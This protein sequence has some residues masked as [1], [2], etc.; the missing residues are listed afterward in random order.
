MI[1]REFIE[2]LGRSSVG[3]PLLESGFLTKVALASSAAGCVSKVESPSNQVYPSLP[4][5]VQDDIQ[6]V[7]GLESY[8]M[9]KEGDTINAMGERFGANNDFLAYIPFAKNN[10]FEG[11]LWVN[12]EYFHPL[13]VSQYLDESK[14]K[15]KEQIHLERQAVGGSLL[16]IKK[17]DSGRWQVNLDSSRNRR[18]TG[19]SP[20]SFSNRTAILGKSKAFGTLGNCC[21]GVTPWGNFLTAEE[22]Y[23]LFYGEVDLREGKRK[24]TPAPD[25]ALAWDQVDPRPPEHYGWIVEVDP[26]NF[27]NNKKQISLGRFAHE[28]ATVVTAKDGRAVVYMGDDAKDE[29]F[30]KFISSKPGSLDD[31]TLY[32]ANVEKGEWIPLTLR[33]EKLKGRF[34]S[35]LELMIRTREAAKLVGAT[36]LDRP[37]DC[38]VDPITKAIYLSCTNNK[39]RPHGHL[40]KISEENA[41]FTSTHFTSSIFMKGGEEKGFS[42]PDNLAFDQ[43]GNLWMVTDMSMSKKNGEYLPY[44]NNS[45]FY[46]PLHGDGAGQI[47]RFMTAPVDA[48]MTGIWFAPDQETLFVSIQHPG[49]NTKVLDPKEFTSHWPDGELSQPKSA[50]IGLTGPLMRSLLQQ[51]L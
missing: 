31:G 21:G 11:Y 36:P 2:W 45:L 14:P 10:I 15:T 13:F 7:A 23:H 47:Y 1:R 33:H 16:H 44:G 46:I 27:D 19:E 24:L 49:E 17:S 18:L 25:R 39:G 38:E 28:G 37:E 3:L 32:V 43:N 4:P 6:R 35:K 29:H 42:C 26:N 20:I 41:D 30:Y 8:V 34:K 9:I 40:L 50:V 48:E 12:H 5:S 51:K 22:N